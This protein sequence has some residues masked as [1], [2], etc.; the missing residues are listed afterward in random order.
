MR[1]YSMCTTICALALAAGTLFHT[2]GFSGGRW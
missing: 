2:A 1:F